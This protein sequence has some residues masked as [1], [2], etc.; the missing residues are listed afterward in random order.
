MISTLDEAEEDQRR[1]MAANMLG[2]MVAVGGAHSRGFMLL[3]MI[4]N[5][6][7][8]FGGTGSNDEDESDEDYQAVDDEEDEDETTT[9]L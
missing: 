6:S 8:V 7:V 4:A 3:N 2:H 5:G 1:A 9:D